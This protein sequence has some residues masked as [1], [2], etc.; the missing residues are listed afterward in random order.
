L[1]STGKGVI[2]PYG[3]GEDIIA[4]LC[5]AS[6]RYDVTKLLRKAQ[7]YSVN[8]FS[9]EMDILKKAHAIILPIP[10]KDWIRCLN[11]PWYDDEFGLTLEAKGGFGADII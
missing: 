11:K 2:V 5:S 10:E 1:D 8:V 6:G 7:R 3:E 4:E 9:H